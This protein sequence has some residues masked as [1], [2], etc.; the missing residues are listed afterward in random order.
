M[1]IKANSR[2]IIG[3]KVKNLR[4]E[5]LVPGV[6]FGPRRTPL[7][8]QVD[9][10]SLSKLFKQVGY[11]KFFDLEIEESSPVKVLI[12]EIP[13]HPINDQILTVNF[14]Q[15]AEDIKITVE[16]PITFV[17]EAPA[18]KQNLGFLITPVEAIP[19]HCLP[20]DLPSE[21]SV[22]ISNLAEVGAAV[23]VSDIALPEGVELDSSVDATTALVYIA[24]FQKEIV[25]EVEP[26]E[27]EE[28]AE[29]ET[30]A[31]EGE[32]EGDAK[33]GEEK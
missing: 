16:V 31:T 17:G 28:G 7:N 26:T 13:K 30:A 4:K 27:G 6:V 23:T 21:I 10:K 20:K 12:Q 25:E 24:S 3:K 1:K 19:L 32:G 2:E 9:A 18:V 5:G 15:V 11:S 14:Y 33:S 29:G 22:D 8:V